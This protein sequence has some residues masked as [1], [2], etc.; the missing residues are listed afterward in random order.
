VGV[1]REGDEDGGILRVG[2]DGMDEE[3]YWRVHPR[4]NR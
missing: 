1:L 4:R 2:D 3:H